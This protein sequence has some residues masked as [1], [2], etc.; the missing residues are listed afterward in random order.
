MFYN[1]NHEEYN[2]PNWQQRIKNTLKNLTK[3][4]YSYDPFLVVLLICTT[5]LYLFSNGNLAITD[6]VE[7]N[8]ALT[9]KEMV[10]S[11]DYISPRIFDHYWY[12]KPIFF[13]LELVA[14]FK[15]FGFTDFAA[16]FFPSLFGV[17]NVYLIYNF[18]KR[19]MNRQIA[20]IAAMMMSISAEAWL[21]S[22]AAITDST[23]VFFFA[24]TLICFYLG[25]E[26]RKTTG[27]SRLYYYG[28]YVCAA[29][30]VLTKG[31]VGFLLPGLIILVF[32]AV[33]KDI[34]ELLHLHLISGLLIISSLGGSWYIYMYFVHGDAFITTFLGVH[35]W[36]RATVSEH[37]R[38][39]VWYYYL[40]I[41]A[42]ALIPWTPMI[43]VKA[44]KKIKSTLAQNQNTSLLTLPR[45]RQ[46]IQSLTTSQANPSTQFLAIWAMVVILFFQAMATKYTTYTFPALIPM[47]ML[48][49]YWWRNNETIV[50]K[51]SI[52]TGIVYII[53]TLCIAIPITHKQSDV[54]TAKYL[55]RY[56]QDNN[57][58]VVDSRSKYHVSTTF[59]S[60]KT[61]NKLDMSDKN[62]SFD[63]NNPPLSW[64]V[65][66]MMPIIHISQLPEDK[67]MLLIT[68][69]NQFP[70]KL[71]RLNWHLTHQGP[72]G[73]I[74]VSN[75]K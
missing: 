41:N 37:P 2:P 27:S 17:A 48:C 32:L 49:A 56:T 68:D 43:L 13:Y 21:F 39:N 57:T 46:N 47:I 52:G 55:T 19:I 8:Y 66:K 45:L 9:A 35:N 4:A 51:V 44:F 29:F 75:K 36:L 11:G 69:T 67:K 23:L 72:E 24:S 54:Y 25:Y 60:G 63:P 50:R 1:S 12:D 30:S 22:K 14:A 5:I 74:Y 18:T 71:S 7:S 65:K 6:P 62:T 53:L 15:L 59:Y 64:D 58:V 31:P 33:R 38:D 26:R 42:V 16:R 61:V 34:K 10:L 3:G 20:R 73:D 28:A 70:A 40:M